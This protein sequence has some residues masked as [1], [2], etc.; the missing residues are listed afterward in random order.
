MNRQNDIIATMLR[1]VGAGNP[2][3]YFDFPVAS[4]GRDD[5]V[6]LNRASRVKAQRTK[7]DRKSVSRVERRPRAKAEA[8]GATPKET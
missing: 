1:L 7:K 3:K 2:S 8:A 6:T 5:T 4:F